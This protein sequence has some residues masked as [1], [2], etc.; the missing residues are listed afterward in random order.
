MK[1][2]AGKRH[3][4]S[5]A[6]ITISLV[7]SSAPTTVS[8]QNTKTADVLLDEIVTTARRKDQ[9]E[10][11]QTVPVAVSAFN[12][13]QLD[14]MQFL[15]LADVSA[16]VPNA[17]A[18]ENLTYPGFINFSMRGTGV[19][20]SA[21]SD[22]PTVG[23]FID[24][25][26]Q[27]I[28]A[29]MYLDTFDMESVEMLRGPQGT[30]FGRNVTGGAVLM[31]T[32][33]PSEEFSA[34]VKAAAGNFGALSIGG[35]VSG[36]ISE[37]KVLGKLAVFHNQRDDY[38]DN[39]S[40][41][42]ALAP[43]AA[44][45]GEL[46]QQIFRGALTW[47]VSDKTE[48][49]IRAEHMVSDQDAGILDN[50]DERALGADGL[51]A[52]FGALN[53]PSNIVAPA[54]GDA[55]KTG[56]D[57]GAEVPRTELDSFSVDIVWEI[58]SGTLQSITAWRDLSQEDMQQDFD[59]SLLPLFEIWEHEITQEQISQEFIYN[60][61]INDKISVTAGLYY[62]DQEVTN[63]DFRVSRGAFG[64]TGAHITYAVDHTVAAG[65][66]SFDF[67][68][69]ENWNLTAGGRF[70][71]EEKTAAISNVGAFAASGGTVGC[72][73][74]GALPILVSGVNPKDS[75]DFSTCVPSFNGDNDW[76]NFSPKVSIQ[77][78]ISDNSQVYGSYSRGFRSGGYSTRGQ[79]G[80]DPLYDEES[81]DAFELG[82]K[83]DFANGSRLN[84]ALFHN[85]LD[86]MQRN[87]FLSVATGEQITR[88]AAEA[89]IRG[90][91][92]EAWIPLGAQ[93]FVQGSLGYVDAE[94][95][96]YTDGVT[97][98]SG[99][100]IPGIGEWQRDLSLIWDVPIGDDYRLVFRGAYHF[101][102]EYHNTDNNEGYISPDRTWYDASITFGAGNWSIK[103]FGK[104]LN[105]EFTQG[106]ATDVGAWVV[107]S[108]YLPRT[109]GVEF[110]YEVR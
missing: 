55:D 28:G 4:T 102:D 46:D 87:V 62:F 27:G 60:N 22:E 7:M 43:N 51:N 37:G 44:D 95:D 39:I 98:F 30:L 5:L 13:D 79:L 74:D 93:F 56:G 61:A 33:A 83:H 63:N 34:R 26:Y 70:S 84:A 81:I 77:Y 78:L 50:L 53:P 20:G 94:Y 17:D 97:D 10:K 104:N 3:R 35:V 65:F 109:Y 32:T 19:R 31:R 82:I 29:G 21:L 54:F 80:T 24:G 1:A 91:E 106:P 66:A 15:N 72:P 99:N 45:L 75:I 64:G 67:A 108:G 18:Q 101:R 36:P 110:I 42:N 57:V 6:L 2:L 23:I 68:L 40:V 71:R 73:A 11:L 88:N 47:L 14:A 48:V 85:T 12:Q 52:G 92:V 89:T 59:N 38:V 9:A 86:D 69:S 96:S 16:V 25:V 49:T 107:T 90:A 100:M 8:A 76:S 105:D 58:G 103:A 41:G